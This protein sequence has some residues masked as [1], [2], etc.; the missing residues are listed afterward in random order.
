M[1]P[2]TRAVFILS[3]VA[4]S[5]ALIYMGIEVRGSIV[6]MFLILAS[7]FIIGYSI[8]QAAHLVLQPDPPVDWSVPYRN[9]PDGQRYDFPT[10]ENPY[11]P[12][13]PSNPKEWRRR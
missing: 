3:L 4:L 2:S 10:S 5:V 6:S 8:Y 9:N 1:S 13:L 11:C 12:N 7:P